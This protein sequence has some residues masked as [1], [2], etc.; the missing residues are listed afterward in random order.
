MGV[1]K[2]SAKVF[3]LSEQTFGIGTGFLTFCQA[4]II[5]RNKV[6]AF[7]YETRLSHISDLSLFYC[8]SC[9]CGGHVTRLWNVGGLLGLN[10]SKMMK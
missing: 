2:L 3:F 7:S 1:S 6:P 4:L 5:Q 8:V 10:A 9:R